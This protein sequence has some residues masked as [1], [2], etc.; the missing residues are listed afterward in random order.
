MIEAG[1]SCHDAHRERF[2]TTDGQPFALLVMRENDRRGNDPPLMHQPLRS[3]A[4]GFRLPASGFRLPASGF[5]LPAS[6][7]RLPAS[8]FRL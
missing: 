4:K 8:G 2:R 6:G 3:Q 7:F 5:R 1:I